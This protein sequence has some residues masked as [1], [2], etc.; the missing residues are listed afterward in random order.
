MGLVRRIFLVP[1]RGSRPV[2]GEG[3]ILRFDDPQHIEQH[4]C[5]AIDGVRRLARCRTHLV[6][7]GVKRPVEK[8]VAVE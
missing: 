6:R 2:E 7:E 4:A 3:E 5:E 8:R 1:E